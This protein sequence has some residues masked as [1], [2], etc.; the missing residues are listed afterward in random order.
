M[1]FFSFCFFLFFFLSNFCVKMPINEMSI[2]KG[3]LAPFLKIRKTN[4]LN[5]FT[6]EKVLIRSN[7]WSKLPK[8]Q[9]TVEFEILT[10]AKQNFA[11]H[12]HLSIEINYEHFAWKILRDIWNDD[13]TAWLTQVI[14]VYSEKAN[15]NKYPSQCLL[16]N[17]LI[18]QSCLFSLRH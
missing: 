17:H 8:I 9:S 16:P 14:K 6:A 1:S 2:K 13:Y 11:T 12:S 10:Q 3:K 7:D 18:W 5:F 4:Q 15:W